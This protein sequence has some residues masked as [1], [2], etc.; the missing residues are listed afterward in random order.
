MAE[1]GIDIE[2]TGGGPSWLVEDCL[3]PNGQLRDRGGEVTQ[4][5]HSATRCGGCG[6]MLINMDEIIEVD[7]S[8]V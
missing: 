6:E 5:L 4:G 8:D 1:G 2:L 3:L 7:E